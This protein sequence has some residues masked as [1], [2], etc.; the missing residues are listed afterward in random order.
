MSRF[1]H[2]E[3]SVQTPHGCSFPQISRSFQKGT[4]ES[5]KVVANVAGELLNDA[6]PFSGNHRKH[7][8]T[9]Q[10]QEEPTNDQI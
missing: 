3:P 5:E 7:T 4:T 9:N 8:S 10:N 2:L 1:D 6:P